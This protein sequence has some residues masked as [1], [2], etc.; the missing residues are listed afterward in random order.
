MGA[1]HERIWLEPMA[2]VYGCEGRQWCQDKV[3]PDCDGDPEPTE[4]IRA[5]LH[6]Q[7]LSAKDREL[8]E[9]QRP[10]VRC[11]GC[12]SSWT[13]ADL[14]RERA[15]NPNLLSCCPER[16]PLTIDQW[17]ARADEALSALREKEERVRVLEACVS[18][19]LNAVNAAYQQA[20]AEQ[21]GHDR[22]ADRLDKIVMDW[23]T[24]ARSLLTPVSREQR[25]EEA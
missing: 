24:Q 19:G 7:A 6:R 22:T 1:D 15:A 2:P 3:W 25:G 23:R 10:E 8:A 11:D 20:S 17:K 21:L 12:G 18:G 14:A 16:K 9:A 5:D 13:E 4:Y